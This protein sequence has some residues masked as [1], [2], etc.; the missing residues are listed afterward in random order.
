M[1]CKL[2]TG[3]NQLLKQFLLKDM[4]MFVDGVVLSTRRQLLNNAWQE[5]CYLCG[6]C[7]INCCCCCNVFFGK[8]AA[9]FA[10]SVPKWS[11]HYVTGTLL[12]GRWSCNVYWQEPLFADLILYYVVLLLCCYLTLCYK[13]SEK[14]KT[15]KFKNLFKYFFICYILFN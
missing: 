9:L 4:L 15:L 12:G 11:S 10:S 2:L 3:G 7:W 14:L 1:Y 5:K 13:K 6:N 8:N